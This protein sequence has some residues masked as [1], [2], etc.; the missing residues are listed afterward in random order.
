VQKC[1]LNIRIDNYVWGK[2]KPSMIEI[3]LFKEK[4][5]EVCEGR[6]QLGGQCKVPLLGDPWK[7]P[8]FGGL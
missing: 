2:K 7:V 5:K 8:L 3:H 6:S 1:V 4:E